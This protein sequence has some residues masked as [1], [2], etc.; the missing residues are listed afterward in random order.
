MSLVSTELET[1]R[2][3]D[4]SVFDE[5]ASNLTSSRTQHLAPFRSALEK[6]RILS[7]KIADTSWYIKFHAVWSCKNTLLCYTV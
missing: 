4:N 3:E 2:F 7:E 6:V 5:N 1:E